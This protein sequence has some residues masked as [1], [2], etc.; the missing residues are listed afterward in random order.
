MGPFTHGM[1]KRNSV[2]PHPNTP[3][4]RGRGLRE[5]IAFMLWVITGIGL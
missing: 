3:P 5:G 4:S 1:Q 2:H